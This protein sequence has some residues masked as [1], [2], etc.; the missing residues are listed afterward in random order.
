MAL[1]LILNPKTP[2]FF[3][4]KILFR[5]SKSPRTPKEMKVKIMILISDAIDG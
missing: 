3:Q 4:R 1:C 5:S 2:V